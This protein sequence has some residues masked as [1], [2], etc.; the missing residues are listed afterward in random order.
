MINYPLVEKVKRTLFTLKTVHGI[1][2]IRPAPDGKVTL[3]LGRRRLK[4]YGSARA[5]A[6]SVAEC[7]TGAVEFDDAEKE[8]GEV[9][10]LP[11]TLSGWRRE[12]GV[13][14]GRLFR[15]ARVGSRN[16]GEEE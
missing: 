3:H 5:A 15:A 9:D 1:F 8:K 13:K 4:S 11:T 7:T 6:A 14:D 16:T 10:V 12:D 2:S